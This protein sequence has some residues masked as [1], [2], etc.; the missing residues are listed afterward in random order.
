MMRESPLQAREFSCL[1]ELSETL[2]QG[3]ISGSVQDMV[4]VVQDIVSNPTF[5]IF[6]FLLYPWS[7]KTDLEW[8]L[9]SNFM[10]SP[11]K[12]REFHFRNQEYPGPPRI[13]DAWQQAWEDGKDEYE[14]LQ[15]DTPMFTRLRASFFK[16]GGNVTA[17]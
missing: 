17:L 5:N 8:Y 1:S 12:L 2:K 14:D 9:A 11:H 16:R 3:T 7:S 6:S 10:Y 15:D 13:L 4:L